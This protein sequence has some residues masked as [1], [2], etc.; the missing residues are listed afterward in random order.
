[1]RVVVSFGG[2]IRMR[3]W[4]RR[5]GCV[6]N[7]RIDL[8]LVAAGLVLALVAILAPTASAAVSLDQVVGATTDSATSA[9]SLAADSVTGGVDPSG[10]A[11][12][13]AP[14]PSDGATTSPPPAPPD[15]TTPPPT[16][17]ST[18]TPP[19]T[20]PP[21]TTA[22][23]PTTPPTNATPSPTTPPQPPAT[24]PNTAT[25]PAGSPPGSGSP[26]TS[27]DSTASSS[28][29][30]TA[31]PSQVGS[32]QDH[33]VSTPAPATN[34]AAA[35]VSAGPEAPTTSV[36]QG[37]ASEPPGNLAGAYS[38]SPA[39]PPDSIGRSGAMVDS[40][41]TDR[42][43]G[44][45]NGA[46]PNQGN[47]RSSGPAAS[48]WMTARDPN[49]E[50]DLIAGNFV[51]AY[52]LP[53][54]AS[55]AA[56]GPITVQSPTLPSV[57]QSGFARRARAS[58]TR[59]PESG[60]ESDAPQPSLLDPMRHGSRGPEAGVQSASGGGGAASPLMLL[61]AFALVEAAWLRFIP[62]PTAHLVGAEA[63][64]LERPG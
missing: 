14:S 49:A 28:P 5:S 13:P 37:T 62:P 10:S 41:S 36:S 34:V 23:P 9:S 47:F 61:I 40:A 8:G 2:S 59:R 38:Q 26:V 35:G 30:P 51:R 1:M 43:G 11:S 52:G 31:N 17:P 15:S 33:T 16:P 29:G 44:K 55:S 25:S 63:H 42:H 4:R 19:P 22:P 24:P 54:P 12:A 56:R 64:R 6:R 57:V 3:L 58:D 20:T 50:R 60:G 32:Q 53:S 7:R 27:V 46:T 48:G 21:N 18:T 45:T 39:R